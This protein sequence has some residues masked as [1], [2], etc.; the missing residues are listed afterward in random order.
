MDVSADIETIYKACKGFG[1]DERA[2]VSVFG[3]RD[4]PTIDAIRQQY[5]SLRHRNLISTLESDLSGS[6]EVA[7]VATA[8]G[9]LESEVYFA[10]KAI[11]GLGTNEKM[12]TEAIMGK[13]NHQMHAM[14]HV[15]N[16]KHCET[17]ERALAGDLSMKTLKFFL[18]ALE[19]NKMD[20]QAPVNPQ[21]VANDVRVFNEATR[22]RGGKDEL[23]VCSIF[24]RS[25]D[26]HLR[27]V[28]QE[29]RRMYNADMPAVIKKD[30]SGHMQEAL[31][32]IIE[33]AIDK[34]T[35]DAKLLEETMKGLLTDSNLLTSRLIRMHWDK[36]HLMSVKRA[37]QS[38]YQKDLTTR[39]KKATSG[40]FGK[41]MVALTS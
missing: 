39:V 20:E 27:A 17:L 5:Q 21:A 8:L 23:A 3:Y 14:K 28:V 36:G 34:A 35:R 11:V 6:F 41:M 40:D 26:V 10:Y 38:L 31:L 2:L 37:Y 22:G 4:G 18:M 9:P 32:Y 24:T 15:Y 12:L 7:I 13:T 30:F 16:A 25:S 29:Y 1:T 19:E 33:G